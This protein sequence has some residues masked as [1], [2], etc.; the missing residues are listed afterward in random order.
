MLI[1]KQGIAPYYREALRNEL[2]QLFNQKNKDDSYVYKKDDGSKWDIYRDG[3]RIYTTI[4]SDMQKHAEKAVTKHLKE[5]LQPEFDK[6]NRNLRNYPFSNRLSDDQAE[7]IIR[8]GKRISDRYRAAKNAGTTDADI[9]QEFSNPTPMR[10]FSWEGD[11]DTVMSPYDSIRYY[12]SFLHAGLMSVEPSTGFV[13]AW[14][15]GTDMDHFAYDHVRTGRRQVGST[16]KPFV[17]ATAINNQVVKPCTTI[18][19]G[20]FCVDVE[21]GF[22]NTTDRWCPKKRRVRS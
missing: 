19:G 18:P 21:D 14:V 10:V 9:E 11:I 5:T 3:L 15:G 6:N 2:T 20:E 17:Y 13:K 12:K 22:G 16:I 1:T 4:N 8:N 7:N